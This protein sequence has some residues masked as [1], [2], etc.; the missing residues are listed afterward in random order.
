MCRKIDSLFSRQIA[1]WAL[2]VATF[3]DLTNYSPAVEHGLVSCA[4]MTHS[5]GIG[6][7]GCPEMD[8][9]SFPEYQAALERTMLA[10]MSLDKRLTL[11]SAL[12]S[13]A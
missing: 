10:C 5:F 9:S 6:M 11:L 7:Q 3:V 1:R 13:S 8:L 2:W 12:I 4:D